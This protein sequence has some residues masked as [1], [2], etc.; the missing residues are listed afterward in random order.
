MEKI[1][2]NIKKMHC[3][4]CV[5]L[6]SDALNELGAKCN[7]NLNNNTITVS[8]NENKV[9]EEKIKSAIKKAGFEV[10]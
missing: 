7:A 9:T 5:T 2:L 1:T 3:K 8:F 4:S 6:I 10:E